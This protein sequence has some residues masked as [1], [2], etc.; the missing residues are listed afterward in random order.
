MLKKRRDEI[1]NNN[2]AGLIVLSLTGVV[3]VI[4]LCLVKRENTLKM[5]GKGDSK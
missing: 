3:G 2:V 1:W 5:L 4:L